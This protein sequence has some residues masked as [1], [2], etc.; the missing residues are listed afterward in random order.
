MKS[1]LRKA[2]ALVLS[3]ITML[4]CLTLTA[5]AATQENI[6][7]KVSPNGGYLAIGDSIGMG[8]GSDG[9]NAGQYHNYEWRGCEGAYTTTIAEAVG[10]YIPNND[11]TDQTSNYWPCCYPG[12]T[13]A[14]M[15]DLL[16]VDD[17]F[18]DTEIDYPYYDAVLK[19]FGTPTSID[20]TRGDKYAEG[21]CGLCG[22]ILEVASKAEL[23]TVELGMCDVFYRA[24]RIISEGGFL[25][26]GFSFDISNAGELVG[27]AEKSV[28]LLREGFDY[29]K[30]N[31]HLVLD[32]LK[33]LNPDATIVI[34]TLSTR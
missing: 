21:E 17:G 15:L 19:Y 23:I 28:E 8:C 11:I 4:S 18:T 13:T 1:N 7:F 14:I 16:G 10:C 34:V 30:A 27:I 33:E 32:K 25:A 24:Y 12:L 9:G 3:V 22:D 29:W 20:G 31:Y 5:F 2:I 6:T 26:D